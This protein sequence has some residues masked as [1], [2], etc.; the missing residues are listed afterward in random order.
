[1]VIAV[2]SAGNMKKATQILRGGGCA[3]A[4]MHTA[5]RLEASVK[6]PDA[7]LLPNQRWVGEFQA[8]AEGVLQEDVVTTLKQAPK[9]FAP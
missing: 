3:P 9:A 6:H 4:T 5:K 8:Q 2:V 7:P 1:M